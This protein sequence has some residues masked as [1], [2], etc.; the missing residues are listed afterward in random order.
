MKVQTDSLH[1]R[2]LFLT[3]S[4]VSHQLSPRVHQKLLA[5]LEYLQYTDSL[6]QFTKWIFL[7]TSLPP[8]FNLPLAEEN[9]YY[10]LIEEPFFIKIRV[11]QQPVLVCTLVDW[12]D[13]KQAFSHITLN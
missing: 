11:S 13:L 4:F 6:D 5:R 2:E 9:E 12:V 1:L 3:G 7:R 8:N 10:I